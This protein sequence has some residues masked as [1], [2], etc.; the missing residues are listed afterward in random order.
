MLYRNNGFCNLPISNISLKIWHKLR[1]KAQIT[2]TIVPIGHLINIEVTDEMILN[3][4]PGNLILKDTGVATLS[5]VY[6]SNSKLEKFFNDFL[7]K[8]N[9]DSAASIKRFDV[10]TEELASS[11]YTYYFV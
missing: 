11:S 1:I 5:H 9:A 3:F 2:K 10:I 8:S 6:H 4:M 7:T